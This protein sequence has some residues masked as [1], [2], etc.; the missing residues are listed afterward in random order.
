[1]YKCVNATVAEAYTSTVRV[2]CFSLYRRPVTA[3]LKKTAI[4]AAVTRGDILYTQLQ[5]KSHGLAL[6]CVICVVSINA[7][8]PQ[9]TYLKGKWRDGPDVAG[10]Y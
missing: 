6:E 9:S 7:G 2:T 4:V 3:G 8:T 10:L 5:T 1:V